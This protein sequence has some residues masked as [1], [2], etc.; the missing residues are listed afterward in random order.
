MLKQDQFGFEKMI[1]LSVVLMGNQRLWAAMQEKEELLAKE[2]LTDKQGELLGEL[3][4]VI[5]EEDGYSRR[6]RRGRAA[7]GSRHSGERARKSKCADCPA[8]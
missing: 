4:G 1:V 3:E 7:L 8:V 5:A 2:T 6:I